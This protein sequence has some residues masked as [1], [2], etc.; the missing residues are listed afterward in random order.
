MKDDNKAYEMYS[1]AL[2]MDA[3]LAQSPVCL[4][5]VTCLSG[6]SRTEE[7]LS[8]VN[9]YIAKHSNSGEALLSKGNLLATQS[10]D[11]IYHRKAQLGSYGI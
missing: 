5:V 3:S 6:M 8:L 9:D 10:T 1:R 11:F 7:A 2:K 4:K